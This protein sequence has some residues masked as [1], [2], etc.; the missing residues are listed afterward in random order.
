MHGFFFHVG[1]P[2]EV[3]TIIGFGTGVG[4]LSACIQ[5]IQYRHSQIVPP[6]S[7]L[8]RN[9][10]MRR[11]LN[12]VRY[13][14]FCQ[15][16]VPAVLTDPV[17]QFEAK[18]RVAGK[19]PFIPDFFFDPTVYLL[20]ESP[21]FVF[22]PGSLVLSYVFLELS[23]YILQSFCQ[24]SKRVSHMSERTKKLQKKY[25][26]CIC[27][28]RISNM[29]E[30]HS[31]DRPPAPHSIKI[32]FEIVRF[33]STHDLGGVE[34]QL[35][36]RKSPTHQYNQLELSTFCLVEDEL[37]HVE[38][39]V[40]VP[41]LLPNRMNFWHVFD[42]ER[43]S[44]AIPFGAEKI[45][46]K[47]DPQLEHMVEG[48][49]IRISVNPKIWRYRNWQFPFADV[50]LKVGNE[51]LYV[52]RTILCAVS[53][54]FNYIMQ[55]SRLKQMNDHQVLY[56]KG[57]CFDDLYDL[58]GYIYHGWDFDTD[59]S[60]HLQRVAEQF[61]MFV[62]VSPT[63]TYEERIRSEY[64]NPD[65]LKKNMTALVEQRADNKSIFFGHDHSPFLEEELIRLFEER[66][67]Q[68]APS[69]P[70]SESQ[71]PAPVYREALHEFQMEV[72][73]DDVDRVRE[74]SESVD[75][76]SSS[77]MS[78]IYTTP[79]E[80]SQ[81]NGFCG[82]TLTFNSLGV[83]KRIRQG[84]CS[85]RSAY[86]TWDFYFYKSTL[87]NQDYMSF[88]AYGTQFDY[89]GISEAEFRIRIDGVN[90]I[91]LFKKLIRYVSVDNN[92]IGCPN[93]L[94]WI[95]VRNYSDG[96]GFVGISVEFRLQ[97]AE[98]GACIANQFSG[99]KDELISVE[100]QL[101]PVN[102]DVLSEASPVLKELFNSRFPFIKSPFEIEKVSCRHFVIMLEYIYNKRCKIDDYEFD[103]MMSVAQRFQIKGMSEHI[104]R[105]Y[106]RLQ[107]LSENE[108][109]DFA[110]FFGLDTMMI[111]YYSQKADL[112]YDNKKSIIRHSLW[113]HTPVKPVI[114]DFPQCQV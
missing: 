5:A 82:I 7:M 10:K 37:V 59:R 83:N 93:F 71:E 55:S 22:V 86:G 94:R 111:H 85:V 47:D 96:Q 41:Q 33:Q 109:Y 24:L 11:T 107:N 29:E 49:S 97:K 6:N 80:A 36:F 64:F 60:L 27:V 50:V 32:P 8:A 44:F 73:E 31:R 95:D 25:F 26:V 79:M 9:S 20:Q 52:N 15:V 112:F 74:D 21:F 58:M 98:S 17:N 101:I 61:G 91:P 67:N 69:S 108:A 18:L 14:L 100:G 63:N 12:G 13:F 102:K 68:V 45:D 42:T 51:E 53:R 110:L 62:N 77:S 78:S 2:Y 75:S 19:Y 30:T 39:E 72:D 23:F 54:F 66:R 103:E 90:T 76:E 113:N 88:G 48:P 57:V 81:W 114:E 38:M 87:N 46:P 70:R 99:E 4:M 104:I 28:Q 40:Y 106:V 84:T 34:W 92:A 35:S 43:Y 56:V 1:V 89:S 3:Q 16:S 105:D 65:P